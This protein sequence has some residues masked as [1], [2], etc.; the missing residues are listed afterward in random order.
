MPLHK[1]ESL[2]L[3]FE[4]YQLAYT[5]NLINDTFDGK[6]DG[7]LMLEGKFTHSGG[8]G[9]WWIR[10]G[11]TQFIEGAENSGDAQNRFYAPLS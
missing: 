2:A 1:L 7:S 3:P 11:T 8:D 10:S 5:P 9:N 6:V 4:S